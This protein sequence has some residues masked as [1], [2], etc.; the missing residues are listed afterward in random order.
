MKIGRPVFRQMADHPGGKLDWVTSDCQLAGR[1]IEQGMKGQAD[2]RVA[3]PITLL[4]SAYG[5][6]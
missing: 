5:L 2:G 3:H 4:R 1:H 6:T